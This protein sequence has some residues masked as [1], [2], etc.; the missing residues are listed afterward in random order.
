MRFVASLCT[1]EA[2]RKFEQEERAWFDEQLAKKRA[3][4]KPA[5]AATDT[6]VPKGAGGIQVC[7][8]VC[9][10]KPTTRLARRKIRVP[11]GNL[12]AI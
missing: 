10:L 2:R 6:A 9:P 12:G 1:Q 3:G 4:A 8:R 11:A 7:A 5:P